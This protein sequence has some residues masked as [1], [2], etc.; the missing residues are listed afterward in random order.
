[1][2][3]RIPEVPQLAPVNPGMPRVDP[4]AAAMPAAALGDLAQGIASIS[5]PFAEIAGRIQDAENARQLSEARTALDRARTDHF[6]RLQTI[7]DPAEH[8]R[9]TDEFLQQSRG[10]IDR[11][12]LAP[13]VRDRLVPW[14][15]AWATDTRNNVAARAAEMSLSRARMAAE[16]EAESH[17]TAGRYDDAIA[18]YRAEADAGRIYP[19]AAA[20]AE[21]QI[22]ETARR[23]SEMREVY[24]DPHAWRTGN[25]KPGEGE[26]ISWWASKDR[27]ARAAIAQQDFDAAERIFD[28]IEKGS[29]KSMAD[30]EAATEDLADSTRRSIRRAAGN[31]LSEKLEAARN[32]PAF[33]N[34]VTGRAAREIAGLDPLAEDFTAR[35]ID[36]AGMI[37]T[38]PAGAA[39]DS[40]DADLRA[41]KSARRMEVKDLSDLAQQNLVEAFRSA[42]PAAQKTQTFIDQGLLGAR[43]KLRM[44]GFSKDQVAKIVAGNL[45][46]NARA[47]MFRRLWA[48]RAEA[49]KALADS[50]EFKVGEAFANRKTT[51][52]GPS[53]MESVRMDRALGAAIA[54]FRTWARNNPSQLNNPTAV[55]AAIAES[56]DPAALDEV[57]D[58]LDHTIP[59]FNPGGPL[60][61]PREAIDPDAPAA[62][63]DPDDPRFLPNL[64]D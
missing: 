43:K 23:D 9:L 35:A 2:P 26:D 33:V 46:A 15:D 58:A 50:F 10:I 44:M 19:E 12:D 20:K 6:I 36:I 32:D 8:L 5:R 45:S 29:V 60:L 7:T 21:R 1:M 4:R 41:V 54:N 34:S 14:H 39:R 42:Q 51:V 17:V 11:P 18:V 16:N 59:D 22:S 47:E 49:D 62:A 24:D 25:P 53:P 30:V 63:F 57:I 64:D 56:I 37:R 55:D 38:L 52:G 28:G 61:P 27:A 3:I 31:Y 40:L 48:V 13:A